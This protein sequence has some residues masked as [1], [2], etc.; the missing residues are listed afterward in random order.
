[1]DVK[2]CA[3][4]RNDKGDL[5]LQLRDRDPGKE[6]WVLF[7]GSVEEGETDEQA[8]R[9]EIKE[10]IDYN[11]KDLTLFGRYNN[12]AAEMP[13]F[14]VKE[15]VSLNQLTLHEGSEMRFFSPQELS[16]IEIGFGQ[17]KILDDFLKKN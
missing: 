6:K 10:E 3:I 14:I 11:I 7:G 12:E 1:M 13:T 16:T 9:R 4:I 5:L 2:A 15:P 8:C 17:K